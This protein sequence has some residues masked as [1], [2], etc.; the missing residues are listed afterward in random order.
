MEQIER[1]EEQKSLELYIKS[2]A[3]EEQK[4]QADHTAL[5]NSFK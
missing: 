4:A 2:K 3:Q 1:T 5:V